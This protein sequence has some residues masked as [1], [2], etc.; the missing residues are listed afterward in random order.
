MTRFSILRL[1]TGLAALALFACTP[2]A[3][4]VGA[5]AR[6]SESSLP[7]LAAGTTQQTGSGL[8]VIVH[9]A[10]TGTVATPGSPVTV[11][12]TGWLFDE[13]ASDRKGEK[14][15]SSR[16]R[17]Q[18]FR[19]TLGARQ[20][21]AGWDEGVAGM[22]VGGKRTLIIP[23]ELA[24]GERGFPPVIPPSATLVFDVALLG[25]E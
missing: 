15:D 16:D 18:P 1:S 24:Y 14:F 19:F 9:E 23:P 4:E 11:H 17:G 13:A 21:I 2:P 3:D 8:T 12:Y 20:V 5:V 25:V 7:A 6:R 10:G 22:R